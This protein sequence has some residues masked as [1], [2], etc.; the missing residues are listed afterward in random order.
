MAS[1]PNPTVLALASPDPCPAAL[2]H[3]SLSLFV[4]VNPCSGRTLDI[5]LWVHDHPETME[6]RLDILFGHLVLMV[7]SSSAPQAYSALSSFRSGMG[8]DFFLKSVLTRRAL[9]SLTSGIGTDFSVESSLWA[10]NEW[11][12]RPT[13]HLTTGDSSWK[14]NGHGFLGGIE[15]AAWNECFE[16]PTKSLTTGDS[17]C[18]W[19][20]YGFLGGIRL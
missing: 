17:S 20:G 7:E 10:C 16:R 2:G 12:E 1:S 6:N 8:M 5:L 3:P 15:F 18:K 13:E 4:P 9:S 19:N 14:W 11:S